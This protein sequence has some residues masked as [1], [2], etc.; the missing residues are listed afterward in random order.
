MFLSVQLA[1]AEKAISVRQQPLRT[2]FGRKYYPG[3]LEIAM[4]WYRPP[5]TMI[6][7][8]SILLLKDRRHDTKQGFSC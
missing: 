1:K 2:D 3:L 5:G 4:L 7:L 6:I 8:L